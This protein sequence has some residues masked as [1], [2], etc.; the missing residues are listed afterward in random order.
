MALFG[1]AK[2]PEPAPAAKASGTGKTQKLDLIAEEL[3]RIS[4]KFQKTTAGPLNV[5]ETGV[6]GDNMSVKIRLISLREDEEFKIL[7]EDFA[8]IP[9]EKLAAGYQLINKMNRTYKF[10]KFTIDDDGDVSCQWDLPTSLP[11]EVVGKLGVEIVMRMSNIIDNAYP[12]F[13]KLIWA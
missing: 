4:W 7:S 2:K 5:I 10:V 12:E 3:E 9:Q 8:K 1:K 6:S 13:M 11:N